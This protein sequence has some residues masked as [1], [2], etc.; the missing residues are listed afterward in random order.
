MITF[1]ARRSYASYFNLDFLSCRSDLFQ[2]WITSVFLCLCIINYHTSEAASLAKVKT[3]EKAEDSA[4]EVNTESVTESLLTDIPSQPVE[5]TNE[6]AEG[7]ITTSQSKTKSIFKPKRNKR[8]D[9]NVLV[10]SLFEQSPEVR[11]QPR[12]YRKPLAHW[13]YNAFGGGIWG[14]KKRD[15]QEEPL[16]DYELL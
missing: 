1:S 7:K 12:R 15:V 3:S 6:Q 13:E 16:Y 14:R 4:V 2:K 11:T 10:M 9:A 5:T 8:W